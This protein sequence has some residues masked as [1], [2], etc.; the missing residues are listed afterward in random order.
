MDN[1]IDEIKVLEDDLN[2]HS[3]K[4]DINEIKNSNKTKKKSPLKKKK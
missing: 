4:E 1:E 3:L 2:L